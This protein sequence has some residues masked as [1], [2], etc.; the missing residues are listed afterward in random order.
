MF[1][2]EGATFY[3]MTA[4]LLCVTEM[5]VRAQRSLRVLLKRLGQ[6]DA[7]KSELLA[8]IAHE[9]RNPLSAIG[10]ALERL[11]IAGANPQAR[12]RAMGVIHRQLPHIA[13]LTD[14]L[15][16]ASR[17]QTGKVSLDIA[18][19]RMV[20]LVSTA[21]D[22][23]EVSL[24]QRKQRIELNVD[25]TLTVCADGA[26]IVQVLA[27]VLHNASKYSPDG[28]TITVDS[29]MEGA[30]ACIKVTDQG[31]GIPNEQLEWVFDTYAQL[32]PGGDGLGLG[33]SLV[34][35]LV[36]LHGGTI[37]ALSRG[38]GEGS[39]FE[40]CLPLTPAGSQEARSSLPRR[41]AR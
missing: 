25:E 38:A 8:L 7:A 23:V 35:K 29:H 10:L 20:D 31:F 37:K 4:I 5:A 16:D 36:H 14:D 3:L 26:R 17:I 2:P 1:D 9:L 40:I 24:D 39:T 19:H 33:L 13:R 34:R 11:E 41:S 6:A 28:T 22:L 32:K 15:T 18:E 27:N 12:E 30:C 21:R